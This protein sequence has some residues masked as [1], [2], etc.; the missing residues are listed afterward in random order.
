M[1]EMLFNIETFLNSY[2]ELPHRLVKAS[3]VAV[4]FGCLH[5]ELAKSL[6]CQLQGGEV[7]VVCLLQ[8]ALLCLLVVAVYGDFLQY[9]SCTSKQKVCADKEDSTADI[10]KSASLDI[11]YKGCICLI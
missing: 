8:E 2:L 6:F 11:S 5:V 10:Q 4:V 9:Q 3:K 7:K 1:T